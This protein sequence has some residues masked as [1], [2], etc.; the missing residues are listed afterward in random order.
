MGIENWR[1]AQAAFKEFC[2]TNPGLGLMGTRS[3]WIWFRRVHGDAMMREGVLR[4]ATT[5]ALLID[6]SRFPTVA[7]EHLTRIPV[8][9]R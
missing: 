9:A 4:K 7:F 8:E 3:S 6:A 2:E 1:P 5:R